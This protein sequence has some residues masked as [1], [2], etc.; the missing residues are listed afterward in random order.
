MCPHLAKGKC[1]KWKNSEI[2]WGYYSFSVK[3]EKIL[4][5]SII[6]LETNEDLSVT[7]SGTFGDVNHR[8]FWGKKPMKL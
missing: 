4:N 8:I 2:S 6:R 1:A 5:V 7:F 3:N